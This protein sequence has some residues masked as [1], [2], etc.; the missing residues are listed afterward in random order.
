M[1]IVPLTA[2]IPVTLT[3]AEQ[4]YVKVLHTEYRTNK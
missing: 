2:S 3:A 4:H 1:L